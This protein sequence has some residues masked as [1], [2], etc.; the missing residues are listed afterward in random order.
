MFGNKTPDSSH[1]DD[2]RK[3][4]RFFSEFTVRKRITPEKIKE[5][6]IDEE[7]SLRGKKSKNE[8][9]KY[10]GLKTPGQENDVEINEENRDS[11]E[12]DIY[13]EKL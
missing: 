13:G 11:E 2:G 7:N 9:E 12:F 4:L 5:I 6:L 10:Q 8:N 3:K 1:L